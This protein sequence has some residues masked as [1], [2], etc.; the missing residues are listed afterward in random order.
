MNAIC[1]S[2]DVTLETRRTSR[3]HC[4]A[5]GV[6]KKALISVRFSCRVLKKE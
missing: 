4:D 3:R 1:H 2:D 6:A 5:V